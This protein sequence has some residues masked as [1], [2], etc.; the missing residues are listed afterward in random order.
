MAA[1]G[2]WRY[3]PLKAARRRQGLGEGHGKGKRVSRLNLMLDGDDPAL[4]LA[5]IEAARKLRQQSEAALRQNVSQC[6]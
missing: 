6:A 4:F 1:S 5:R 3:G 2:V